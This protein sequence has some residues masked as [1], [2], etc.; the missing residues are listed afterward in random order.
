M[1]GSLACG[2]SKTQYSGRRGFDLQDR[3][4]Q[5]YLVCANRFVQMFQ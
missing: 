3:S 1:R 4:G 2:M 5:L